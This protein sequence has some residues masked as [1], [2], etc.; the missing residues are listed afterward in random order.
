MQIRVELVASGVKRLDMVF[1][2]R[3]QKL[4]LGYLD[5]LVQLA[6]IFQGRF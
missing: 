6:K 2:K 3:L 4:P 1:E 5:T